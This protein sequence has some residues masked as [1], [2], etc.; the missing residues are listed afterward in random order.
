MVRALATGADFVLFGRP[1]L[2]ALAADGKQGLLS[3]LECY[4]E[5]IS[6]VMAQVGVSSISEI[7]Q[8]VLA[9]ND[10]K[11]T[12]HETTVVA[13]TRHAAEKSDEM[14]HE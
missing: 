2:Y 11:K 8:F 4:R 9:A 5:D 1:A 10:A 13:G 6:V 14:N 3:L 12:L 7:N